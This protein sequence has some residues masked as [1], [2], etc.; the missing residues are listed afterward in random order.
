[1]SDKLIEAA[2]EFL[3]RD[4][5]KPPFARE[6]VKLEEESA[7]IK[8]MNHHANLAKEASNKAYEFSNK[9]NRKKYE[10]FH[11]LADKHVDASYAHEK[12]AK[13]NNPDHS[14]E[15]YAAT[16]EVNKMAMSEEIEQ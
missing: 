14:K 12:A 10:H 15:A 5:N 13:T 2:A 6:E 1:M 3:A 8:L 11:D 7:H 4:P 16:K 9:N